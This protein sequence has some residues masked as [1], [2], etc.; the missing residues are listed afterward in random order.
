LRDAA[1]TALPN[2]TGGILVGCAIDGRPTITTAIEI[3]DPDATPRRYQISADTTAGIVAEAR[4]RDAR[5]GYLGDWHSHTEASDPSRLDAATM[6][7]AMRESDGRD[8][9]LVLVHPNEEPP[10]DIRAYITTPADL[11]SAHICTTGDLPM[12]NP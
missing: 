5:M 12:D 10:D 9:A 6:R 11:R 8:V 2:E 4:Q 7:A 1:Q 3:P